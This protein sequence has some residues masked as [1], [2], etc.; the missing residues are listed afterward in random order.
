VEPLAG[1]E[2]L[3]VVGDGEPGAGPVG[4]GLPVVHLVLQCREEAL[5]GG[6]VPALIC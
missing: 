2:D 1:V 3:D 4:E 6:V 5:G